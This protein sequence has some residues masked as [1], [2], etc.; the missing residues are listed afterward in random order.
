MQISL[1]IPVQPDSVAIA[2]DAVA[3]AVVD[4]RSSEQRIEDLRLLTS[5]I[6][7]NALR[8]AG[9]DA[10]DSLVV[11]V[12]I[13]PNRVRV[14]VSDQGPGFDPD[15]LEAPTAERVG[16]WGLH[17]VQQLADRWGVDRNDPNSVWFEL[18]M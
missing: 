11:A 8:H 7:T 1:K 5:E 12:D 3:R 6:V 13:S 15:A 18:A 17:L 16:G 2:R 9:M 10:G 14:E 4:H